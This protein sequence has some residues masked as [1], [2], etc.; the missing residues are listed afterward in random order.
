MKGNNF[1]LILIIIFITLAI[2]GVL[3]FSGAIPIGNDDTPGALGT[4]TLWGT[5]RGDVISPKTGATQPGRYQA[6]SRLQK[7]A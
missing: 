3:V 4:V 7:D 2:F 5:I 1:Q 6:A